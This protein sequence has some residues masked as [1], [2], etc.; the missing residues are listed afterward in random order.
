M[1]DANYGRTILGTPSE[2]EAEKSKMRGETAT[3]SIS[4]DLCSANVKT[5]SIVPDISSPGLPEQPNRYPQGLAEGVYGVVEE[6]E[7]RITW[8]SVMVP[9]LSRKDQG[10]RDGIP[11]GRTAVDGVVVPAV[12]LDG[13]RL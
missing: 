11:A 4:L 7:A 9:V 12:G 6:G 8:V 13:R 2:A 10:R 1:V 3:Y 5:G